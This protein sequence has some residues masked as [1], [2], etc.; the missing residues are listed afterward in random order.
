[1]FPE[2]LYRTGVLRTTKMWRQ[3]KERYR[4]VGHRCKNCGQLWWPGRHGK[5]CGK[6]NARDLEEYEFSHEGEL[7]VHHTEGENFPI[8]PIQGFEV[9]G[10]TRV[11]AMVKLTR[12]GIYIGPTE[13]VDCLPEEV[14]D[15][16]KVKLALRKVRRES[17]GNWQYRFMWTLAEEV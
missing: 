2:P 8:P 17:N 3:R 9:Y 7:F 1:M 5:V 10:D 12:E 14:K 4:L 16:M 6:C 11:F 13:I 15:G